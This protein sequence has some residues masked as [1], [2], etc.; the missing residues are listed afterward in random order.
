MELQ[1]NMTS[2]RLGSDISLSELGMKQMGKVKDF[3]SQHL[4]RAKVTVEDVH[5]RLKAGRSLPGGLVNLQ[6]IESH[7][8]T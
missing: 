3:K 7:L 4:D 5:G 1:R 8:P 2:L 6:R